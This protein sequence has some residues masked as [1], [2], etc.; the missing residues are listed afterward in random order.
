MKHSKLVGADIY[1]AR[2]AN[3]RPVPGSRMKKKCY[4]HDPPSDR[5]V[6][7]AS[8]GTCPI[9]SA[10]SP[11][12]GSLHDELIIK[13]PKPK[14]LI[15][16]SGDGKNPPAAAESRPCYRCVAYMHSAGIKRVFWTN[17]QGN[18]EGAKVRDLIDQLDGTMRNDTDTALGQA[19]VGVFVTKH[20][21]LM[22]RRLL[23]GS[24]G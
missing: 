18:W 22:L 24:Q 8:P 3:D 17:S 19:S 21:V 23:M 13:T 5:T 10:E 16:A 11:S 12:T 9:T 2:L 6:E 7:T 14:P 4:A 1:V 20:E 15:P